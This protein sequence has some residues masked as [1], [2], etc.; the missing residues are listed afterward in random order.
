MDTRHQ[1]SRTFWKMQFYTASSPTV[2]SDSD[3]FRLMELMQRQCFLRKVCAKVC[4]K[5]CVHNF[6]NL[7]ACWLHVYPPYSFLYSQS[8]LYQKTIILLRGENLKMVSLMDT[9]WIV[10]QSHP[11]SNAEGLVT[12]LSDGINFLKISRWQVKILNRKSHWGLWNDVSR[13]YVVYLDV[14]SIYVQLRCWNRKESSCQLELGIPGPR[15][16]N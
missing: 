16:L 12:R 3:F 2:T 8:L 6:M 4:A 14:N 10:I 15:E 1:I 5:V 9:T 13:V 7:N 11:E